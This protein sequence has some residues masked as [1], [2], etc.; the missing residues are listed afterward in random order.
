MNRSVQIVQID[1]A[2]AVLLSLN[3]IGQVASAVYAAESACLRLCLAQATTSALPVY[4]SSTRPNAAQ[5]LA[6]YTANSPSLEC[7]CSLGDAR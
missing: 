7:V 4:K 2:Q 3:S 6:E 1:P 5:L